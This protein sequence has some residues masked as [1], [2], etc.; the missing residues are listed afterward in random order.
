MPGKRAA[1][2]P[3]KARGWLLW[4]VWIAVAI[5]VALVTTTF[6]LHSYSVHG[7]SMEPTLQANNVVLVNR[8]GKTFSDITSKTYIPKRGEMVV[9]KNPFYDQGN[10][11]LYIVKRV[12]GLPGDRMVVQDGRVTVYTASD[13]ARG[14]NPDNSIGGPQDPTSG[15]V[16]RTVPDGEVFV[17][18]DNRQGNNSLDSRNGMSTVPTREIVGNVILRYW[19]INNFKVF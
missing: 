9:F 7:I 6:A 13:P 16:D 4:L 19:P 8:L 12:V 11:D 3:P 2:I 18:G 1:R 5:A 14:F 15:S 17:V 10:P